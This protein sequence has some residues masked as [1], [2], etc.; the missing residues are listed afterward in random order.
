MVSHNTHIFISCPVIVSVGK[1]GRISQSRS[2]FRFWSC[3]LFLMLLLCV[4]LRVFVVS[5]FFMVECVC[6]SFPNF[7]PRTLLVS[8]F[9]FILLIADT[10]KNQ[11][12][13]YILDALYYAFW[14]YLDTSYIL[15][16][17][18]STFRLSSFLLFWKT[19]LLF[20]YVLSFSFSR[21]YIIVW[22]PNIVYFI[23]FFR[24]HQCVFFF[25]LFC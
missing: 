24:S 10:F 25:A 1:C 16:L 3:V 20:G 5:I 9:L 2:H 19:F 11:K 7:P 13:T 21:I 8:C 17:A 23:F 6:W 18:Y 15:L 12:H 22:F 14:F 4:C